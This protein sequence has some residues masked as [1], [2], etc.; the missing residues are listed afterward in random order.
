MAVKPAVVITED[1][2]LEELQPGDSLL[3]G[4]TPP[5]TRVGEVLHSL[6]GAAFTPQ[7]PVT[8]LTAGWLVNN[9]GLLIVT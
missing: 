2:E 5:A 6:D 9:S 7:L 4:S 1:G 3:G 8:T